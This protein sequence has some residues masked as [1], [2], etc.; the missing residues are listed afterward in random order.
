MGLLGDVFGAGL[1]GPNYMVA[2]GAADKS[3]GWKNLL[4]GG[5][6]PRPEL[7]DLDPNTKA[8]MDQ[9]LKNASQSNEEIAQK[10]VEG[11]DRA[12]TLINPEKTQSYNTALSM[13]TPDDTIKA[14]QSRATRAFESGNIALTNQARLMAAK[15]KQNMLAAAQGSANAVEA[16]NQHAYSKNLQDIYNRKVIR[17]K[18]LGS[19]LGA[20]GGAVGFMAG[21]PAGASAGSKAGGSMAGPQD[22]NYGDEG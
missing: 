15:N 8:L 12:K 22:I 11:I 17:N 2:K 13:H 9:Q 5:D 16:I 4:F 6:A 14:L 21:G 19:I 10:Q 20:I 1:G 18:T 3:G 7:T